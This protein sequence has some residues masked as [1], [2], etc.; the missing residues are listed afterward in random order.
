M[1][2]TEDRA[3]ALLGNGVSAE[4]TATAL[5]VS[6]SRISQLLSDDTFKERVT[7][8]RY[9]N[10]QRHN[11]RDSAYDSLEDKLIDKLEKSLPMMYKPHEILKA[12][13]VVNGA[14]RRGQSAPE[15]ITN[16]QNIV[17][18]VL[19]AIITQRFETNI[20]NQVIKAG[21]QELLTMNS[22]ALLRKVESHEKDR[23]PE[24]SS[25]PPQIA[26]ADL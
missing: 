4:A 15:Q 3:L 22:S 17:N 16:Q 10:L 21:D 25:N 9:E 20:N 13:S 12:I 11:Q 18:L 14:K 23:C 24:S 1:A 7:A 6:P 5:G 26:T 19:P 2:S 8:L